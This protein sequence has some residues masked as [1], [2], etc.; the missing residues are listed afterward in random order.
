MLSR[1]DWD[2]LQEIRDQLDVLVEEAGRLVRRSNNQFDYHRAK[3]YWLGHMENAISGG[4]LVGCDMDETIRSLEPC[5]CDEE[6][7]DEDYIEEPEK[8]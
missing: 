1:N 3:A 5:D 6:E 2:R 4:S 8:F 7:D